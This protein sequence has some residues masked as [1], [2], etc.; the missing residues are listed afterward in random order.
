MIV[1]MEIDAN[2]QRALAQ[3]LLMQT[4]QADMG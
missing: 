2:L 1:K 3:C 4:K